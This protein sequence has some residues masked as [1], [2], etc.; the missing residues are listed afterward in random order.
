VGRQSRWHLALDPPRG[1]LDTLTR[2][3]LHVH[4][5]DHEAAGDRHVL[6]ELTALG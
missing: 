6:E 5:S 2:R 3:W 1:D 4:S